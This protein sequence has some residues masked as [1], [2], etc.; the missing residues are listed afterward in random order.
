MQKKLNKITG[1]PLS[2]QCKIPWQFHDGSRHSC[3]CYSYNA[4]TS[5]IESGG[6]RNA[7]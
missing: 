4:G 7:I 1:W 6:G 3:P 5:V 2:R